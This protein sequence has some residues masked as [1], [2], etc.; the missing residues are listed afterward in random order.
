M[1]D[2]NMA[3]PPGQG[4]QPGQGNPRRGQS[5]S[6]RANSSAYASDIVAPVGGRAATAP[7][8]LWASEPERR[9]SIEFA[10]ITA[11]LQRR[12]WAILLTLLI[13][14]TLAALYLIL[15]PPVYEAK[16]YLQARVPENDNDLLTQALGPSQP[17]SLQTQVAIV[18]NDIIKRDAINDANNLIPLKHVIPIER[19]AELHQNSDVVIDSVPSTDLMEVKA[20]ARYPDDAIAL[21]NAV[22]E[23]YV[24]FSQTKNGKNTTDTRSYVENQALAARQKLDKAQRALRNYK[25]KNGVFNLTKEADALVDQAQ[26]LD[27]SWRDARAQKA[28]SIAQLSETRRV[29]HEVP[30]AKIVPVEIRRKPEVESLKLDLA[31][32][33][34]E[35]IRLLQEFTPESD[36]VVQITGQIEDLKARLNNQAQTE[37]ASWRVEFSPVKQIAQQDIARLR[38]QIWAIEAQGHAYKKSL[39]EVRRR[40]AALPERELKLSQLTLDVSSQQSTYDQLNQRLQALRINEKAR[41]ASAEIVFEAQPQSA[42]KIRPNIPRTIVLAVMAGLILA[43]GIAALTDQLD[44]RLHTDR[45]ATQMTHLPVLANV[46]Y[47]DR[48]AGSNLYEPTAA[49]TLL[50]E[51]FQLLATNIEFS[52]VDDTIGVIAIA[53]GLPSEGKS[54]SALNLAIAAALGG[55]SVIL[56]DCDLR[57]PTQ[58]R[59]CSLPNQIGFSNVLTG[60]HSL[61]EALQETDVA[62]FRVL[63]GGPTPPNPIRLL[64]SRT[65]AQIIND[66]RGMADFIVLDTPP[67]LALADAQIIT[68]LADATLLVVSSRDTGRRD[69]TRCL[70]LL[71]QSGTDVIGVVLNKTTSREGSGYYYYRDYGQQN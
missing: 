43:I 48:T 46:P 65:A 18:Q 31:R 14:A 13:V 28:A 67:V 63:T 27:Q 38:G 8:V 6:V 34:A 57:R 21:A 42:K 60:A 29:A 51:T 25:Q 17:R 61:S 10:D 62:G 52:A 54:T 47:L 15:T 56:V 58:H 55:R 1:N 4:N 20:Q 19:R 40:L 30:P 24:G 37:T 5:H 32:L 71:L 16:A 66:L 69:V 50:L 44:D 49:P 35:K 9:N 12:R 26:K 7:F 36:R 68:A 3:P 11:I 39:G 59:L 45:E 70:S 33:E 53:S 22:C 2:P 23:Y 41:V 64:K